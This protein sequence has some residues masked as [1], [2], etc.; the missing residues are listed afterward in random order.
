MRGFLL[1][2]MLAL[3]ACQSAPLPE[4]PTRADLSAEI[5]RG[6]RAPKA[7]P[8]ECWGKD[9]TPAIYETV[10]EQVT[11]SDPET[12]PRYETVTQQKLV[13]DRQTVWFR[14][15]CPEA[16]TL[17]FIATLQRAL[18]ARG[19]YTVPLTGALDAPT[20]AAVRRFQAP[21]GLDSAVLS[22][23]AARDL[24]IVPK[25]FPRN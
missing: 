5:R 10:T 7:A 24:G 22:L 13:Q 17:D 4:A 15:P 8:G 11:V 2:G 23:A 6:A 20:E 14:T 21:L 9:T 1:G 19:L 25:E 18:K 3:A 16:L 12:A